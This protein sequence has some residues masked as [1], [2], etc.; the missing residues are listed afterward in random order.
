MY[1][2]DIW[3][4]RECDA[5]SSQS[6]GPRFE[7]LHRVFAYRDP[8]KFCMSHHQHEG[9]QG[10]A[11]DGRRMPH[12]RDIMV[13]LLQAV[14]KIHV[15]GFKNMCWRE[16]TGSLRFFSSFQHLPSKADPAADLEAFF[17]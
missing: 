4:L 17:L 13:S 6:S 11:K 1:H 3:T 8:T 14:Y 10:H 2:N 7:E 5:R 12:G 16:L 9:W 15:L